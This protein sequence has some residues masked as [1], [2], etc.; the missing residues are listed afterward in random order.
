MYFD[1]YGTSPRCVLYDYSLGFLY[2]GGSIIGIC[3]P[4]GVCQNLHQVLVHSLPCLKTFAVAHSGRLPHL[5][6]ELVHGNTGR[7]TMA[8]FSRE[9]SVVLNSWSGGGV[10]QAIAGFRPVAVLDHAGPGQPGSPPPM[11]NQGHLAR[12]NRDE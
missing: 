3:C 11:C 12:K 7:Y 8:V 5:E 4:R 2:V 1:K 9:V 10:F 6:L